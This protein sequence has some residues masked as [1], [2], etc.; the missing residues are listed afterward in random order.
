[1]ILFTHNAPTWT[2][3]SKSDDGTK[4]L[5]FPAVDN[6]TKYIGKQ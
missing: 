5:H 2:K 6:P 3:S 1:M 4:G